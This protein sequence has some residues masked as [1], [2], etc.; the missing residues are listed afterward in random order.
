VEHA[1]GIRIDKWLFHARFCRSR[2]IAA[3]FVESGKVRLN[4]RRIDKPATLVRP[5]D[6]LTLPAGGSIRVVRVLAPGLR[7]GPADEARGL[8]DDLSRD[9]PDGNPSGA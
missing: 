5:G 1:P 3:A 4:A 2:A 9:E 8:Y 7:R 6:V